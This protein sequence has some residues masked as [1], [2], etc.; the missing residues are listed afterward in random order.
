MRKESKLAN[1]FQQQQV[2]QS[3]C[4]LGS[5]GFTLKIHHLYDSVLAVDWVLARI[6]AK[7]GLE[8][9][10]QES[11]FFFV[12]YFTDALKE[13][14]KLHKRGLKCH[15]IASS[16]ARLDQFKTADAMTFSSPNGCCC[17][18]ATWRATQTRRVAN[19]DAERDNWA[20]ELTKH[21]ARLHQLA[22]MFACL[23]F[24]TDREGE[25]ES[26]RSCLTQRE[27][28]FEQPAKVEM[29]TCWPLFVF[30]GSSNRG[31]LPWYKPAFEPS[32][33]SLSQELTREKSEKP[34]AVNPHLLGYP[35]ASYHSSKHWI[36]NYLL[37]AYKIKLA[38]CYC[39]R[40]LRHRYCCSVST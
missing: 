23:M 5:I 1:V 24:A 6:V 29:A 27:V 12:P 7:L 40:C 32:R 35:E 22:I 14:K 28:S 21:G 13:A 39:C 26:R 33:E 2:I 8:L 37:L 11:I 19:T 38:S 10:L 15:Q 3:E 17:W 36:V 16:I 20:Q 31:E 9:L 34:L 18:R 25:R 4:K 30:G